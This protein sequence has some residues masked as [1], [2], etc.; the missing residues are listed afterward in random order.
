MHCETKGE[1]SNSNR[2]NGT[3]RQAEEDCETT[4][5]RSNPNR[6]Y[7]TQTEVGCETRERSNPNRDNDTQRQTWAVRQQ[8]RGS[9]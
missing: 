5:E 1:R 8:E 7:D 4:R 9:N 2:D 3:Q 6:D